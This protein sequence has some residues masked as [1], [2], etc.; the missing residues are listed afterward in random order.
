[1]GGLLTDIIAA[2]L[3]AGAATGAACYST[4]SPTC[5]IWGP[6][7]SRGPKTGPPRVAL[8]FDDGPLPGATDRILDLLAE[9]NVKAAFFVIGSVA[10]REPQLLLRIHQEGHI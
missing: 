4:F 6:L 7:V 1:M 8:T 5:A 9:L 3:A 10:R 2:S